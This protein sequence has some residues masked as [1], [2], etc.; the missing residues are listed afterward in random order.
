[1]SQENERRKGQDRRQKDI[2]PPRNMPE[3]RLAVDRRQ[4]EITE[5]SFFQ[6]ASHFVKYQTGVNSDLAERVAEVLNRAR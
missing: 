2:G 1:M 4:V 3:R 5:V 6:W